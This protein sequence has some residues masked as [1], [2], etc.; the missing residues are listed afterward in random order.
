MRI[1]WCW[2]TT[3]AITTINAKIEKRE[4]LKNYT[5][6]NEVARCCFLGRFYF[7][8]LLLVVICMIWLR[9]FCLFVWSFSF[10]LS[11]CVYTGFVIESLRCF[12][13]CVCV[14]EIYFNLFPRFTIQLVFVMFPFN[15]ISL[16]HVSISHKPFFF[17]QPFFFGTNS[18]VLFMLLVLVYH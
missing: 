5:N 3:A 16:F 2:R 7:T 6:Q 12:Y 1:K 15:C 8:L 11:V 13:V 9:F 17:F 14:C 10:S 18:F 4:N